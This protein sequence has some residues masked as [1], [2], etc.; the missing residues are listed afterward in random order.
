M[1][2]RAGKESVEEGGSVQALKVQQSRNGSSFW[3]VSIDFN[4]AESQEAW[5]VP[6]I[7]PEPGTAW[8]GRKRGAYEWGGA[9]AKGGPGSPIFYFLR[10]YLR[11]RD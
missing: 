11:A 10:F 9:A 3:Q 8:S 4:N 6:R 7:V 2:R 5:L 1:S